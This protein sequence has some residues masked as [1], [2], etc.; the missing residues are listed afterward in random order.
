MTAPQPTLAYPTRT[1]IIVAVVLAIA[2]GGFVLAGLTAETDPDRGV[3]VN[4][5]L[6]EGGGAVASDPDG[7]IRVDPREGDEVLAQ[8]PILI[9]LSPTWTGELTLLPSSG[10][11][12]PLPADEVRRTALN[13]LIYVPGAGMTIERLPSGVNCMRATVWDQVRGREASE[14]LE[15]WCFDVT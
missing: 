1:K 14:R 10:V 11:A 5:T 7:V 2:I 8:E 3:F 15:S 6:A 9:Q 4:G 13:E 12:I